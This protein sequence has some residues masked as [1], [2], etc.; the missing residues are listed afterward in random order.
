MDQSCRRTA[1]GTS[2]TPMLRTH[3]TLRSR[4]AGAA[5]L[6]LQLAAIV[7]LSAVE[8]SHNHLDPDTVEWHG[9]TDDRPGDDQ[10]AHAACILCGHGSAGMLVANGTGAVHAPMIHGVRAHFQP[11]SRLAAADTGFSTQPRAPPA[12]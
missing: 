10:Y 5:V 3:H 6:S 7:G 9:H 2:F 4:R 8:A 1:A 11:W 12:A